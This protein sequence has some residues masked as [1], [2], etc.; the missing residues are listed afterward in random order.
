M[1]TIKK[2]KK[3][4]IVIGLGIVILGI[5]VY[6]RLNPAA[7]SSGEV[8]IENPAAD[9]I[10]VS[11]LM[12]KGKAKGTWFFEANIRVELLDASGKIIT[13]APGTAEGEWMTEDFVPFTAEVKFTK[14]KTATGTLRIRNDNP[15]DLP[16]NDKSF[17]VPVNFVAPAPIIS[18]KP[19]LDIKDNQ[20]GIVLDQVGVTP[21]SGSVDIKVSDAKSEENK[22]NL[23]VFFSSTVQDPNSMNCAVTYPVVHSVAATAGVARAALTELLNGPTDSEKKDGYF[24]SLPAGLKLNSLVL[25]NGTMKVDFSST[26]AQ[27]GS[28]KV[29][30]IRS[31]ITDTLKQF[32]TVKDV[33]ISVNGKTEGVLQP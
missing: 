15:S 23:K 9:E 25:D 32:S 17:D 29:S 18:I 3:T 4:A 20:T 10:I 22:I 16:E 7:L 13:Q 11:P 27:G 2:N 6:Y 24:T 28:C 21:D 33:V 8:V 31:Q 1:E 30:A 26:L 19:S 12:V 14:P 5:A